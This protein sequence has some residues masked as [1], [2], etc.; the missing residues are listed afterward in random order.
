[1]ATAD[2]VQKFVFD[3]IE[4]YPGDLGKR[5]VSHFGVSRQAANAHLRRLVRE[6]VIEAEGQTKGRTY[7]LKVQ[8][9][10]QIVLP[11]PGLAEDAAWTRHV[12]PHL[13]GVAANVAAICNYGVTEMVNNAIDHSGGATMTLGVERTAASIELS[14]H[15]DGVGIFSKIKAAAG[16]DDERHA[17]LEV[18]KGKFT[19]DPQHHTGEGIFFTSRMFDRFVLASGR[20]ALVQVRAGPDWLIQDVHQALAGTRI[21]MVIDPLSTSTDREVFERYASE[22]DDYA[23]KR[24]HVAVALAQAEG[25]RLISRSQ[26]KRVMARLD[27]FREVVLD[28]KGVD[29]IGPAFADEIYRV[30]GAAHPQV[31]LQTTNANAQV[32]AMIH[33]ALSAG[34]EPPR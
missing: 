22:Q 21:T 32:E 17:I 18:A 23:F 14:V 15:D 10:S 33:R 27:R 7:R 31:S 2:E 11:I 25:E 1:M 34:S 3:H 19:T 9:R 28:F 6:G 13:A 5:L 16:L 20:L 4:E 12:L 8:A 29:T 30:Y 24:T 26:A